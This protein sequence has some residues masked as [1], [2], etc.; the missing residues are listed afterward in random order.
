[1]T[2]KN[3]EWRARTKKELAVEVWEQL[4]RASVGAAELDLIQKAISEAFGAG[5]VESPAS[6]ARLL[7]DEGAVL[8]HPEVL[9]FDT[10]WR[11]RFEFASYTE[12]DFTT[13]IEA[14]RAIGH[15]D[16][17]RREFAQKK[18]NL[19]LQRLLEFANDLRD[20]L[21]LIATSETA[22]ER[23]RA[24]AKEIAEWLSIWQRTPGL[25]A[26]WL[27]LRLMSR[28]FLMLF[29]DFCLSHSKSD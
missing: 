16:I 4:D 6:I 22:T 2:K 18:D 25:F 13:L 23:A 20:D 10:D 8:R 14:R 29:P 3:G 21:R 1:L 11:Q 27:E 17:L 5:A 24:E 26:D 15:L 12:S 7:A 28:E 9:E 19:E